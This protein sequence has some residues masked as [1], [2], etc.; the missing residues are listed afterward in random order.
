[1][2]KSKNEN[3]TIK[4]K[5]LR[6]TKIFFE[7]EG[8][9]ILSLHKCLLHHK[10]EHLFDEDLVNRTYDLVNNPNKWMIMLLGKV[11]NSL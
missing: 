6:L 8:N 1:M 9:Q 5:T 2:K 7:N 10:K 4:D 3:H 11:F